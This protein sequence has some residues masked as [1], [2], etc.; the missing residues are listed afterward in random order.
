MTTESKIKQLENI[1]LARLP[2]IN[3]WNMVKVYQ[4]GQNFIIEWSEPKAKNIHPIET[5]EVPLT[6]LDILIKRNTD[7]LAND[8]K[9][10]K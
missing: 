6:D 8:V 7:R 5:K 1:L 2:L 10:Y 9:M 4:H 3:R